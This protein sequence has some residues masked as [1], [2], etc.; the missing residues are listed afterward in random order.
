VIDRRRHSGILDVL[1]LSAADYD[2]E[3]YLVVA[4]VR[5]RLTMSKQISQIPYRDVQSQ[6][7]ERGRGKGKYRA[8]VSN[9]FAPF[10]NLDTEVEYKSTWKMIREN[11]NISAKESLGYNELKKHKLC[12]EEGCSELLDQRKQAK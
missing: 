6:E 5:D 8:E 2:T 11:I 4:K 7:M 12:F 9:R 3:H 10:G 1:S